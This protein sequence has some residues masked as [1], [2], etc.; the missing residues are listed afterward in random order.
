[1]KE[2]KSDAI[3]VGHCIIINDC[4]RPCGMLVAIICDIDEEYITARY[5]SNAVHM[6]QCSSRAKYVTPIGAFGVKVCVEGHE[7]WCEKIGES[8]AK[9]PDGEPRMWQE[10]HPCKHALKEALYGII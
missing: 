3:A 5:L 6:E 10:S 9:Y 2:L 8:S 4:D 1:M 7:Y